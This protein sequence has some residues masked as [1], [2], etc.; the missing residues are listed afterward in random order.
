MIEEKKLEELN[1]NDL[2]AYYNANKALKDYYAN[3]A[4]MNAV[5]QNTNSKEYYTEPLQK[6]MKCVTVE[7]KIMNEFEKRLIKEG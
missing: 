3:E 4:Q 7:T 6:H 5:Y 1:M 2:V